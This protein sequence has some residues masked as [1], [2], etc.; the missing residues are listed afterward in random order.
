MSVGRGLGLCMFLLAACASVLAAISVLDSWHRW[1]TAEH[2]IAS[3]RTLAETLRTVEV[4]GLERAASTTVL[5]AREAQAT[6]AAKA[7]QNARTVTDRTL[8]S[9]SVATLPLIGEDTDVTPRLTEAR[10]ALAGMRAKLDGVLAKPAQERDLSIADDI[11]NIVAALQK[12]LMLLVNLQDRETAQADVRAGGFSRVA[13]L[14][15]NLRDVSGRQNSR[16]VAAIAARRR[17]TAGDLETS[18]RLAGQIDQLA[19]Q[20]DEAFA[21]LGNSP[22]LADRMKALQD[23]FIRQGR[24][25]SS[26][27]LQIAMAG[28]VMDSAVEAERGLTTIGNN[29]VVA[30]RDAAL[31]QSEATIVAS[32]ELVRRDLAIA[33]VVLCV[34]VAGA[35]AATVFVRRRITVPLVEMTR[36]VAELAAGHRGIEVPYAGRSD[37]IGAMAAAVLIFR[38][39][40]VSAD[41]LREVQ[42]IEASA[43]AARA[44]QLEHLVAKFEASAGQM[45]AV[46]ASGASELESTAQSMSGIADQTN[47]RASDVAQAAMSASHGV[48]TVSVASEELAASINE[49]SRQVAQSAAI[50]D[51]AVEDARRTDQIV[52]ALAQSADRIGNVVGLITN[53]AGQTNLLALNATIEAARAGDAGKGFAVVASE[54]KSLANQTMKATEEIGSQITQIQSATQEAVEAIRGIGVVIAEVSSIATSIAS[55][56]TQQGAATAEIARNV[57]QTAMSTGEVTANITSV[58]QAANETG[59]AADEVLGAASTLAK[60][61]ERLSREVDQF[62]AGV[63]AA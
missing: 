40:L 1:A 11:Q 6:N 27:L 15:A 39:G 54:V 62:V 8:Q 19:L 55:A 56:V 2:A 46:L 30:M 16:L 10:A 50:T 53:I 17:M 59:A 24:S 29:A 48:Q 63:R 41:R 61:A 7:L 5:G 31:D 60:Q 47:N 21:R 35:L 37:E 18:Q 49:I 58:S 3:T 26:A 34:T 42:E 22:V 9:L 51:R 28:G 20:I 32:N 43:K 57:Q 45:I 13:L 23:G 44:V 52:Q 38:D 4:L 14:A 36:V 33:L 12:N 25:G